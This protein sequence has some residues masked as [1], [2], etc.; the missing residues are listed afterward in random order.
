[1]G[2]PVLLWSMFNSG[3][4]RWS[5]IEINDYQGVLKKAKDFNLNFGVVVSKVINGRFSILSVSRDDREYT[6]AEIKACVTLL[7]EA[8]AQGGICPTLK[9]AEIDI[10]RR[11]SQGQSL[12]EMAHTT[13]VPISTIKNRL[14]R[15]RVAL[16]AKS[17]TQAVAEAIQH[18]LF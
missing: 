7:N 9:P 18:K 12:A 8:I 16:G 1:M 14:N 3:A 10:L 13:S 11:L 17:S 6:D 15:A 5:E 2:D 4:K